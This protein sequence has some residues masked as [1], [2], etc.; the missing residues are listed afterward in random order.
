[1][2]TGCV[3]PA[4]RQRNFARTWFNYIHYYT[5]A[6]NIRIHFNQFNL[7]EETQPKQKSNTIEMWLILVAV[8]FVWIKSFSFSEGLSARKVSKFNGG[9]EKWKFETNAQA[10]ERKVGELNFELKISPQKRIEMKENLFSSK[11]INLV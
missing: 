11:Q 6:I 2:F 5:H 8:D 9:R 1:M 10:E 4:V 7:V 3:A